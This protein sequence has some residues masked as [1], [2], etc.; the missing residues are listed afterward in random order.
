MPVIAS[1]QSGIDI[2]LVAVRPGLQ[3]LW[4]FIALML[5]WVTFS[6][7]SS[8]QALMPLDSRIQPFGQQA[9]V[10][11]FPSAAEDDSA[12]GEH[13][14]VVKDAP[15]VWHLTWNGQSY[16]VFNPELP[17]ESGVTLAIRK[18]SGTRRLFIA[19]LSPSA[20]DETTSFGAPAHE[21]ALLWRLSREEFIGY[22]DIFWPK[23]CREVS[24]EKQQAI[25]MSEDAIEHCEVSDWQ[26]LE[27][28][29]RAYAKTQPSA[30]GTMK[31]I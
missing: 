16:D 23:T 3:R 9:T 24:L 17:D 12:F 19:Q 8:P 26:Q 5:A 21:Y 4:K 22:M 28:L 7:P 2:N 18:L 29:M 31:K 6:A 27:R 11:L 14:M 30:D 25:G 1:Y 13:P 10:G 15:I 20:N